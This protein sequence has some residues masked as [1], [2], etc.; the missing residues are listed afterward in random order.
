MTSKHSNGQQ[1]FGNSAGQASSQN[2]RIEVVPSEADLLRVAGELVTAAA[3][4]AIAQRSAFRIALAGGSTPRPLYEHLAADPYIDWRKWHI[5]WG[6]ERSVP[7]TDPESNYA[8]AR[9]SLLEQLETP[10][11][12]VVRMQAEL[13]PGEAA[14]RYEQSV[15][16][17]VPSCRT[18]ETGFVPRFDM[19]VL[20]MG[21]DGHT[22]GLFPYTEALSESERIVV[23][24]PVPQINT[25]RITFTYPLINAARRILVL[26]NGKKKAAAL[27]SVISGPHEP[28]RLPIQALNPLNGQIVWLVDE[29]AFSLI[30]AEM[31]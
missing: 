16:E 4:V 24:N 12:L 19:I 28:E 2:R 14:L 18:E 1:A 13:E 29:A 11:G 27:R 30:E 6:D 7:P 21:D 23:A 20:G 8:M 10:P 15:R 5:F 25:T 3:L 31:K 22:A 9:T 17:L 26:V